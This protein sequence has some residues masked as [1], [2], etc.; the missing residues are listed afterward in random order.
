MGNTITLMGIRQ[1]TILVHSSLNRASHTVYMKAITAAEEAKLDKRTD[2]SD[3]YFYG[4][5]NLKNKEDIAHIKNYNLI[6]VNGLGMLYT[7][8]D[9]EKATFSLIDQYQMG[10]VEKVVK[11]GP[12]TDPI[13]WFKYNHC[14]LGKPKKIVVYNESRGYS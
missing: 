6:E 12:C 7:T 13:A 3:I 9:Y 2:K 4:D 11:W 5:I 8:F 14:L 10:E 1:K